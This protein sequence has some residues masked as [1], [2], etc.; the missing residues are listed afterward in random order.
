MRVSLILLNL[1]PLIMGFCIFSFKLVFFCFSPQLLVFCFFL[2]FICYL[3]PL[4]C[5]DCKIT[6]S[7]HKSADEQQYNMKCYLK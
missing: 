3:H 2:I 7:K 4:G 1:S 5:T 6:D